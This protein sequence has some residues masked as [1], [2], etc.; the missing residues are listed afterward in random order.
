MSPQARLA[1]KMHAATLPGEPKCRQSAL[2]AAPG[3]DLHAY[4]AARPNTFSLCHRSSAG[5][6]RSAWFTGASTF[7]PCMS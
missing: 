6:G 1:W 2:A 4:P 3:L 5:S 7:F